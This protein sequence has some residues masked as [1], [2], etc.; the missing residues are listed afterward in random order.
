M[1]PRSEL[2]LYEITARSSSRHSSEAKVYA[3]LTLYCSTSCAGG[4]LGLT[5]SSVGHWE[6]IPYNN[7]SMRS[8]YH[9]RE[10]NIRRLSLV[11]LS[12]RTIFHITHSG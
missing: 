12:R 4:T 5:M 1:L 7:G 6:R 9:I 3:R 2:F 10:Y 11:C 8:I